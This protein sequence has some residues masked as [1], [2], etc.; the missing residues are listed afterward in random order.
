[1]PIQNLANLTQ[2]T[3][4]R[5]NTVGLASTNNC[6]VML[7]CREARQF[8]PVHQPD[9]DLCFLILEGRARLADNQSE[10]E[11]GP[12]DMLFSPAGQHRGVIAI[13]RVTAVAF[14][15][16]PPKSQDHE[17]VQRLLKEGRWRN[18]NA[19]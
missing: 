15:A 4:E 17:Q 11:C 3:A 7:V 16:P 2:F 12:G 6:K 8:I 14:V 5:Y 1:M 19:H 9:V 18:A 13:T 10:Q